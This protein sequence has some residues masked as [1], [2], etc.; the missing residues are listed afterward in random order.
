MVTITI[1]L[2]AEAYEGIH[3]LCE[4]VGIS[5]GEALE[6][7]AIVWAGEQGRLTDDVVRTS[8]P[9]RV[10]EAMIQATENTD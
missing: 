6:A 1:S 7:I 9:Q 10:M 2:P 4:K 8:I 3:A 5:V